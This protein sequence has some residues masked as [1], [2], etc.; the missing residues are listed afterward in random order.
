[1]LEIIQKLLSSDSIKWLL[2]AVVVINAILSAIS[3]GLALIGKSE[4]APSWLS[5]A[6]DIAKKIVDFLSANLPHK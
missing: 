6:A 1:M 5:K 2:L 3:T 4:K